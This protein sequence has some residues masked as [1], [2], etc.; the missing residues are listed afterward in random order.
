MIHATT[1]LCVKRDNET[2][3]ICDGQVT[4][5]SVIAKDSAVKIRSINN[6]AWLLGFAGAVVHALEFARLLETE[7]TQHSIQETIEN[8]LIQFVSMIRE[9]RQQYE[10]SMLLT[11]GTKIFIIQ[12]D[13]TIIEYD[14]CAG[15][16]S[17]G[18]YAVVAAT[19]LLENTSLTAD[20]VAEKAMEL[21]ARTCIYTNTCFTK[22]SI[23]SGGAA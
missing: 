3:M 13:G 19:A 6:G 20:E 12:G 9:K 10:T 8:S 23:T 2:V 17:G 18:P 4:M 11:D 1:V 22:K 7:L 14:D 21:A 16:G 15:I 5:G